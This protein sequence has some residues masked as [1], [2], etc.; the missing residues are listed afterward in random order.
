M[1][2]F[3]QQNASTNPRYSTGGKD[4]KCQT[5]IEE[6]KSQFGIRTS[7]ENFSSYGNIKVY[8]LYA[9]GNLINENIVK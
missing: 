4:V 8:P 1:E 7:L 9:I 6:K 5:F 2:R 3:K